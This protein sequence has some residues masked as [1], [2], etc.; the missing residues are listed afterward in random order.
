VCGGTVIK[1][2]VCHQSRTDKR[3]GRNKEEE[4]PACPA[5]QMLHRC[6]TSFNSGNTKKRGANE[7]EY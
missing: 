4:D 2:I 7:E 3:R 6:F 5:S 1:P